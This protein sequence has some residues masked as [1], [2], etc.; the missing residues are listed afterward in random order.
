MLALCAVTVADVDVAAAVAADSIRPVRQGGVCGQAYWNGRSVAFLYPPSFDFA[1]VDAAV[2]YRYV[3]EDDARNVTRF[4]AATPNETLACVWAQLPCGMYRLEVL[5]INKMGKV[6]GVSGYRRFW[7]SAAFCPDA[8]ADSPLC[9]P[10]GRFRFDAGEKAPLLYYDAYRAIESGSPSEVAVVLIHGW[11]GHVRTLL[12]IFSRA[13]AKRAGG[14]E[15]TPYV[16][17]PQFP[18]RET[19]ASNG[20]PSDGRAVWGDSWAGEVRHPTKMGRAEDDWRGGGDANGTAFSSYDYIDA[21]FARF[22]DRSLFP[23][24]RRVV[25]AGFSAGGQFAGRYAAIGKGVVRDGVVVEY[26]AM[27][28]STEFR[29]EKD[30]PWL[31]G[32]KGRPRYAAMLTDEDIMR[33]LCSRRVWRGCGSLDVKGRPE[34]SLDMTPPAAR[35]GA[36]RFERFKNFERY[37]ARFPEWKKQVSFHVFKGIGHKEDLCYPDKAVLDFVFQGT[38]L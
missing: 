10:F 4:E 24:L 9:R 19:M 6:E 5:G 27:S 16:L 26:M 25:L 1:K 37:L 18:R 13:L 3:L 8:C 17:A 31:Y 33:N 20:E 28:P 11:G 36:N 21:I 7:K 23:N 22:A 35:Q 29:F 34:T 2:R 12:P 38:S 32:L 15:R 30:D 14:Q